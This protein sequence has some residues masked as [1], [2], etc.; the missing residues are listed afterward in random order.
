MDKVDVEV[1]T[2]YFAHLS[3]VPDN[4]SSTV[5][6]FALAVAGVVVAEQEVVLSH[7]I[8][9]GSLIIITNQQHNHDDQNCKVI[10]YHL[11]LLTSREVRQYQQNTCLHRLHIIWK[12]GFFAIQETFL[13]KC[14]SDQVINKL[15]ASVLPEHSR[16]PSLWER[17]TLDTC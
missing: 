1:W 2:K 16:R 11:S 4:G 7:N 14:K 13:A 6:K 15:L 8:V 12:C 10:V 3:A 5:A 9:P 17:C